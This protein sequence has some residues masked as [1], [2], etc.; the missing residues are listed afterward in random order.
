MLTRCFYL[1]LAL[2]A[3][4]LASSQSLNDSLLLHYNFDGNAEDQSGN[5]FHGTSYATWVEDRF[6]NP[7]GACYLNSND[8]RIIAPIEPKLKPD[9]PI[10]FSFWVKVEDLSQEK[11]RFFN[12]DY[13]DNNNYHG[14]WMML[15]HDG[16]GKISLNYGAGLGM[17]NSFNRRTKVSDS[18]IDV[19]V[20]HHIAAVIRGPNDMDIFINCENAGGHYTG[21]GGQLAYS[22]NHATIGKGSVID[23][24]QY[25]HGT[26]DDFR[27]WNRAL[28]EQDIDELCSEI[29]CPAITN[30]FTENNYCV[31]N[32]GMIDILT[33]G[34]PNFIHFSI[35]SGFTWH[36]SQDRFT[37]LNT[38][39]YNVFIKTEDCLAEYVDNPIAIE[40]IDDLTIKEIII[41]N[42]TCGQNNG[43]IEFICEQNSN[44]DI[45]YS[46]D[47]G[48]TY[49]QNNLFTEL[50]PDHYNCLVEDDNYCKDDFENN[51]VEL[52]NLYGDTLFDIQLQINQS[53]DSVH[54]GDTIIFT[55]ITDTLLEGIYTWYVGSN[56]VQQ[57][58]S[59]VLYCD[60]LPDGEKIFCIATF[61][62]PCIINNSA[63]SNVLEIYNLPSPKTQIF[64]PNAFT[65]NDDG[66]ND[67]F[68][69]KYTEPTFNTFNM[70]IF[71]RWGELLFE[72]NDLNVGWDGTYNGKKCPLGTYIYLI[73]VEDKTFQGTVI[74]V[75]H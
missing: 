68:K 52:V 50:P 69:I 9:L 44:A 2:L 19:G 13:F 37:N 57:S 53:P 20:W 46:I 35:D 60:S 32:Q 22:D 36:L 49:Q 59:H 45:S 64:I 42:P 10:S 55:A 38:G 43:T 23:P 30:V 5:N 26:I 54:F 21:S 73:S 66:L 27:Y 31:N 4:K 14:C 70:L 15:S 25:Y 58:Y 17:A 34:D 18:M 8:D 65:P 39:L 28:T 56:I 1:V 16:Q 11:T 33:D 3:A 71:S 67:V 51:P 48:F 61:D 24:Y 47:S 7:E 72:S 62:N 6:G 41:S 12:T 29:E 40:F 63:Y 74:I 75:R